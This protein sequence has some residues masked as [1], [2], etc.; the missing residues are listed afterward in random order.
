[1]PPEPDT[2]QQR[3]LERPSAFLETRKAP[4]SP[5]RLVGPDREEI[6]LPDELYAIIRDAVLA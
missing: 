4:S 6:E 5:A 2:S 1:M 3:A